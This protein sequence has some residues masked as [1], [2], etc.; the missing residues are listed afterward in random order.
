MHILMSFITTVNVS[1]SVHLFRRSC[2][3]NKYGQMDAQTNRQMRLG[4]VA[5]TINMDRWMR[6]QTDR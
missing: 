3:Y 4:G 2:T 1:V 5:L 6:R